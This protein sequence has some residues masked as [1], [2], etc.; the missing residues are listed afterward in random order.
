MKK[1]SQIRVAVVALVASAFCFTACVE[2][3]DTSNRYTFVGE[4]V[5][6]FLENHENI[7]GKFNY[8]LRRAG[9][10]GLLKAYGSY[11][12]FAPTD[13]AIDRYLFQQDSI[14]WTSKKNHDADGKSKIVWTGITSPVLEDLSDSMC[15]VIANTH[16]IPEAF[17][18]MEMEGDVVPAMN[19][20]NRF[21]TLSFDVDEELRSV[22]FING[23]EMIAV[24]EEVENGVIHTVGDVLNPSTNT[25]PTQI[26]EMPFLSIFYEALQVTRLED[27]MQLYRDETY[28]H[29]GEFRADASM[30]G[31]PLPYPPYR[32]YGYTAFC[33][34]DEV[35]NAMDIYT[36]DDLERQCRVWYPNATS[37]D[38]TSPDNALYKFMAYHL[39]D[40][41]LLYTRLVFY[42]MTGNS[43][44]NAFNSEIKFPRASDRYEH[45]ET[46]QGTMIKIIMPRSLDLEAV[47]NDGVSRNFKSTIFLNYAQDA[48]NLS[49]PFNSTCGKNNIP[50]NVRVLDPQE[51]TADPER[52]PKYNQEA[53]NG[54]I[55]LIDHP[56]VYDEDV[57]AGH[58]L[59]GII[60][61][62][63]SA[64]IPE[65]TNSHM[66]WYDG[67]A[68]FEFTDDTGFYIPDGYT[69]RV[70]YYENCQLSYC[71]PRNGWDEWYGDLM[72]CRGQYDFAYRLPNVPPGTYEIRVSAINEP[73][74]GI[75]QFYVDNEIC[76]IPVS[77][78]IYATD[79]EIGY[80]ADK[81]TEDN[82]IE[83]D[84]VMKNHGYLKLPTTYNRQ[85]GSGIVRDYDHGLRYVVTTKYLTN[86]HHWIRIKNV[87]DKTNDYY[88]HD[89][90][91]IVPVGWIRN[92]NISVFEKRK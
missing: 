48:V 83:N 60:R 77:C 4:T 91:E 75:V 37:S 65:L 33:E 45:Y 41:H 62:D 34:P 40:Y 13:E 64:L 46:M 39:L 3:I 47:D 63:W 55:H 74:R 15:Q 10:M 52:Y 12:C 51:I 9:N 88:N 24:D 78:R 23:A 54:S 25:L 21:L 81:A 86:D 73:D 42:N 30:G 80:I 92:D 84:K 89:Y 36:V 76:G 85:N 82:G 56:L 71:T 90:V 26:S 19:L 32:Y 20:N 6:S 18:T 87:S 44:G 68:G 67:T 27:K 61:I 38:R 72:C 59:N 29:A 22:M 14:Y 69:D 17:L 70:K 5:G 57:M 58:V 53:L 66:R 11:T 16:I 35:F 2:D 31:G 1:L 7:Y 43:K 28:D 50:V 8:I 79:P 49:D